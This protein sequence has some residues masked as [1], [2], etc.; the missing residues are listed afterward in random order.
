VY[1]RSIV[2][3][4]VDEFEDAA[5]AGLPVNVSWRVAGLCVSEGV[6]VGGIVYG[7]SA[8]VEGMNT[9]RHALRVCFVVFCWETSAVIEDFPIHP[10]PHSILRKGC[11]DRDLLS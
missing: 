2:G 11:R 6:R 1:T 3:F 10:S 9:T 5:G 8:D 4:F 7:I